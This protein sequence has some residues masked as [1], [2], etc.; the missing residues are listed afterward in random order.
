MADFGVS[1]FTKGAAAKELTSFAGTVAW[2]APEILRAE[3]TYTAAVDVYAMG[4]VLFEALT[5]EYPF[6]GM[7]LGQLTIKVAMEGRRPQLWTPSSPGE[8]MLQQVMTRCWAQ[9]AVQ[10]PSSKELIEE[11][12]RVLRIIQEEEARG[13]TMPM[14]F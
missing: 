13:E 5:G 14:S 4:M 6:D 12:T 1:R 8:G 7:H 11:M 10:R 9:E 3:E 2:M